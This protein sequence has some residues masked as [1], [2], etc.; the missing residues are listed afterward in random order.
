MGGMRVSWSDPVFARR[1]YDEEFAPLDG[2]SRVLEQMLLLFGNDAFIQYLEILLSYSKVSHIAELDKN[3]HVVRTTGHEVAAAEALI[4]DD[5]WRQWLFPLR[6]TL[7]NFHVLWATVA[8]RLTRAPRPLNGSEWER[9]Y[10]M[11]DRLLRG[12]AGWPAVQT[13][14]TATRAFYDNLARVKIPA[15]FDIGTPLIGILAEEGT[16]KLGRDAKDMAI[17]VSHALRMLTAAIAVKHGRRKATPQDGIEA[18]FAYIKLFEIDLKEMPL[19]TRVGRSGYEISS[20]L[21]G[22]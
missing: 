6:P 7:G 8:I 20:D 10:S 13:V 22:R 4:Y 11:L 2:G 19:V 5:S 16:K 17:L 14:E 18:C 12:G 15:R 3:L 1:W 21:V 9:L